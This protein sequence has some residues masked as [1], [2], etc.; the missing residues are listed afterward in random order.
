[1]L[2]AAEVE[3]LVVARTVRRARRRLAEQEPVGAATAGHLVD[4][5][6]PTSTSLP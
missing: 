1:M 6:P 4:P 3:D 5:G 2:G